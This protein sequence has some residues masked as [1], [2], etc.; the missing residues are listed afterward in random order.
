MSVIKNNKNYGTRVIL[1]GEPPVPPTPTGDYFYVEDASGSDSTLTITQRLG[2]DSME[3]FCSIDQQTWVSMGTTTRETPITATVP[4]NG[5]L[6]LK[7]VI[8][9]WY[10]NSMSVSANYN[11]G[12]NIMS[13]LYGDEYAD[14]TFTNLNRNA[15]TSLFRS[16]TN[17]LN[18]E[19]LILPENVVLDC[20]SSMF[21][22][23]SNLRTAPAL[24]ATTLAEDCY[25]LMFI[26]CTSLA[27]APV[28]PATTLAEQC[29]Y[30]MFYGCS[31]LNKI[32]TFADDISATNC[33][34]GWLS[35]VAATGDFYNYGNATYQSGVS[36]IPSGWIEHNLE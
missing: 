11:I 5:K 17:L 28:L 9:K 33:I 21:I 27:T 30:G 18:A 6:Y 36:G 23:C 34:N 13:L 1:L 8:D 3:V 19:D 25:N 7:T 29:Y 15:F 16:D 12:G 31:N 14:A 26:R 20:Y 10:P 22:D 4:A 2:G 35:G 24:P 32:V